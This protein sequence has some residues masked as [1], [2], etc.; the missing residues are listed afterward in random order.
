MCGLVKSITNGFNSITNSIA[1]IPGS[2]KGFAEHPLS[3]LGH[4]VSNLY[5][6]PGKALGSSALED[7]GGKFAAATGGL[8]GPAAGRSFGSWTGNEDVGSLVGRGSAATAALIAA[9]YGGGMFAGGGATPAAAAPGINVMG[10]GGAPELAS[11]VYGV[12]GT[13]GGTGAGSSAGFSLFSPSTWGIGGGAA[14]GGGGGVGPLGTGL[15][16]ASGASGLLQSQQLKKLGSELAS[17]QDPFGP[18][19]NQYAQELA[20]LSA[21]PDSIT[22]RPGFTFAR[23]QG[24][25]ALMR[26]SAARGKLGSGEEAIA[27]QKYGQ[28]YAGTYLQQEQNRLAQLAGAGFAPS[29]GQLDLQANMGGANLMSG[30]LNTIG[31]LAALKGW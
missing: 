10:A 12:G 16:L 27:L 4:G 20:A 24:Q 11:T 25:Q 8:F 3:T 28:D 17:K 21:N 31:L 14:A 13:A 15:M 19:R 23:D 22:S 6:A 18:Y 26:A 2:I 7:V 30:S 9:A 1:D 5:T 29:G